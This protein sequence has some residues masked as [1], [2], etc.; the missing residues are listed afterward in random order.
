MFVHPF[1]QAEKLPQRNT[2]KMCAVLPRCGICFANQM[3]WALIQNH[4]TWGVRGQGIYLAATNS[5]AKHGHQQTWWWLSSLLAPQL[6]KDSSF[7]N[8]LVLWYSFRYCPWNVTLE[9]VSSGFLIFLWISYIYHE[10]H[11][12]GFYIKLITLSVIKNPFLFS[13]WYQSSLW[14]TEH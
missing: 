1:P 13:N 12:Y 7:L 10:I 11:L 9:F 2:F 6:S 3:H 14:A 5:G 4:V 8:S